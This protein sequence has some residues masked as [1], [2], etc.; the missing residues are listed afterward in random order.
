M[1]RPSVNEVI[2]AVV[3]AVLLLLAAS[4][5]AKAMAQTPTIKTFQWGI[6]AWKPGDMDFMVE[7]DTQQGPVEILGVDGNV[8]MA[9]VPSFRLG[10]NVSRQTLVTLYDPYNQAPSP[11]K[12]VATPANMNHGVTP[13][14]FAV[15]AKQT[16]EGA[17]VV[18]VSYRPMTPYKLTSGRLAFHVVNQSW[19]AYDGGAGYMVT[20][21]P[22]WVDT[23]IQVTVYYQTQK[24][25]LLR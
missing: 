7:L 22:S 6:E 18:P 12:V 10:D 25:F 14:M 15:N 20:D 17:V 21:Y 19:K 2:V 4:Y 16:G 13:H 9:P 3:L 1:R 24:A 8:T 5:G 11:V 23:E